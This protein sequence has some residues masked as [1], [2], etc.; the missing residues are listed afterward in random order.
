MLFMVIAKNSVIRAARITAIALGS[1]T[2][3]F[4]F[5]FIALSPLR[6]RS[7]AEARASAFEI[8]HVIMIG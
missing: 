8:D 5:C 4:A 1:Q 6:A 7:G 3:A 2:D